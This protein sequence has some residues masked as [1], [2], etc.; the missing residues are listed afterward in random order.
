M[1]RRCV[2]SGLPLLWRCSV[3]RVVL[4]A[5]VVSVVVLL[6]LQHKKDEQG[7]AETVGGEQYSWLLL[8]GVL[9]AIVVAALAAVAVITRARLVVDAAHCVAPEHLKKMD[10]H[11]LKINHGGCTFGALSIEPLVIH[12]ALIPFDS[13]LLS[14]G[15]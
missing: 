14:S 7:R 11:H 6:R 5:V 12:Y 2:I 1:G 13:L 3:V 8:V 9:A 4:G 15:S 10:F